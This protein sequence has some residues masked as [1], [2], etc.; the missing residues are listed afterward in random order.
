MNWVALV[1]FLGFTFLLISII[2]VTKHFE[3]KWMEADEDKKIFKHPNL[4]T[5]EMQIGGG[6]PYALL[7][8]VIVLFVIYKWIG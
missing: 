8:L 4:G 2:A 3:R 5:Q 1:V 6:G 7:A